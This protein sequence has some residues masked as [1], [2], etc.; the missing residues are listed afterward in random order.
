MGHGE[1]MPVTG[2]MVGGNFFHT[3]SVEP[4]LGRVFTPE[5]CLHNSR[6]VVLLSYAFWKRQY[7]GKFRHRFL[8]D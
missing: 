4:F 6:P 2:L 8:G 7:G 1:P 3:L 5:E